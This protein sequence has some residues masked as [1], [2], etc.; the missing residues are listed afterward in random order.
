MVTYSGDILLYDQNDLVFDN[1]VNGSSITYNGN[2]SART[3][4][5]IDH[6][7]PTN[8]TTWMPFQGTTLANFIFIVSP[9]PA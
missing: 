4:Y 6:N 3:S 7:H 5:S 9:L 2:P 1:W 8:N